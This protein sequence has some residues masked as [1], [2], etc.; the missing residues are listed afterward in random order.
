MMNSVKR[1][2]ARRSGTRNA[3]RNALSMSLKGSS[4]EDFGGPSGRLDLLLRRLREGVSLHRQLLVELAAGAD[5]DLRPL[6]RQTVPIERLRRDVL[7]EVLGQDL[8]V[9]RRELDAV[10]VLEALQLGDAPD[11]RH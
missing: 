3:F 4:A 2:F 9:H 8:D 5:L 10:R 7:V 6:V 1:I 11:Q